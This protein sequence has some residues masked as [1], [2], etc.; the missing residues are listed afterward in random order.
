MAVI[1]SY[2]YGDQTLRLR[3]GRAVRN[4]VKTASN[5]LREGGYE[6][7]HHRDRQ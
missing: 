1:V 2:F 7:R 5:F 3:D 6:Q 4:A